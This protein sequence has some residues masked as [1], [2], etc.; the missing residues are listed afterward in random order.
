MQLLVRLG[1]DARGSDIALI[2]LWIDRA[3]T[4]AALSGATPLRGGGGEGC[5][6][7]EEDGGELHCYME[8]SSDVDVFGF[9]ICLMLMKC[10]LL[11]GPMEGVYIPRS[12]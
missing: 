3:L 11:D 4:N 6:G 9:D 12:R 7:E 1:V 5:E 2:L 8:K 10:R